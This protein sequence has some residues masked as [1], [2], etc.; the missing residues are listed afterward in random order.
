MASLD[1][2]VTTIEPW[3]AGIGLA[4]L[5]LVVGVAIFTAWDRAHTA[6]LEEVITPTAVGDTHFVPEP[7]GGAAEIGFKYQGQKLDKVSESKVRDAKLLRVGTDDGGIYSLYR[8]EDEGKN[9]RL[10]MKV[11][12]DEFIEV[13]PE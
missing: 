5:V 7:T 1:K 11:G 9:G 3:A 6:S 2:E 8:L 13:K 12:V 4:M 10:F